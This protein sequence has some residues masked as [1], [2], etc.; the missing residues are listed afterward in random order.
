MSKFLV[1]RL[2][3]ERSSSLA[4]RRG[5]P[6]TK[7]VAC[8]LNLRPL[9]FSYISPFVHRSERLSLLFLIVVAEH[10][11]FALLSFF[12]FAPISGPVENSNL[13][14]GAT[15]LAESGI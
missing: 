15:V 4:C 13:F 5:V 3:I 8:W 12:T 11:V 2:V 6:I 10:C 14:E 1:S 9:F 7:E